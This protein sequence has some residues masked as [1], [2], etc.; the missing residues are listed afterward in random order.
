[1]SEW[2]AKSTCGLVTSESRLFVRVECKVYLWTCCLRINIICQ[3]GMQSLPVDL[4]PQNQDHLSEWNDKSTC[5]LVASESRLFVRVECQFYLWTCCLRI[6]IICQS[7]MPS[8]SVDVLP[9]NQD[10]LSEWI[11]KSTCGLVASESG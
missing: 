5:G 9:Q 4:L 1:M 2:N 6:R 3:S 10:Y 11:A 7:G 8:L